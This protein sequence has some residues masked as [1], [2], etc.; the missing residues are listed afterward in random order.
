MLWPRSG[1]PRRRFVVDFV[2]GRIAVMSSCPASSLCHSLP[3]RSHKF[4]F[5]WFMLTHLGRS[6]AL[7]I[8]TLPDARVPAH[9]H[10]RH[11]VRLVQRRFE[12]MP[13]RRSCN[14]IDDA[15]PFSLYLDDVH[16][17]PA[18]RKHLTHLPSS[19]NRFAGSLPTES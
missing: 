5:R 3:M 11:R 17:S 16:G 4:A 13:L 1:E 8:G 14:V 6:E 10:R 19:R 12:G 9:D 18:D 2:T 15:V 7:S